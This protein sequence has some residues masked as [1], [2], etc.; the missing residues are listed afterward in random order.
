MES[1][2]LDF[3]TAGFVIRKFLLRL[4]LA[5]IGL[6]ITASG[7]E[8]VRGGVPNMVVSN[9]VSY[10][11]GIVI[12]AVCGTQRLSR[13]LPALFKWM[14]G[15]LEDDTS[16]MGMEALDYEYPVSVFPEEET[17]NGRGLLKFNRS[18]FKRGGMSVQPL[19][20]YVS[21]PMLFPAHV[22][23]TTSTFWSDLLW[24]LFFPFTRFHITH[25]PTRVVPEVTEEV[26]EDTEAEVVAN[27]EDEFVKQLEGDIARELSINPST[28]TCKDKHECIKRV[29]HER[30]M[31]ERQ[32]P[33]LRTTSGLDAVTN[34]KYCQMA[35]QVKAVLPQVPMSNIESEVKRTRNVDVAIS[36]FL[37][38]SVKYKP[39]SDEEQEKEAERLNRKKVAAAQTGGRGAQTM[40]G[41]SGQLSFQER[42]DQMIAEARAKY[43]S[44]HPEYA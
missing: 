40:T 13:H 16:C 15:F 35:K 11:D 7:Y 21:R 44:L 6:P 33:K 26:A 32:L 30:I 14:F 12:E 31:R 27:T 43:L 25:L 8:N 17:T 9:H 38:G 34:N 5:L 23:C 18:Y 36:R 4:Y 10:L 2:F 3:P 29:A 1:L 39:L 28:F 24:S 22:H 41:A 37:D 20:V 19:A 42:K